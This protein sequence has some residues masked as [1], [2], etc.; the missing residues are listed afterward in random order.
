MRGIVAQAIEKARQEKV[1]GAA[2]E[3]SVVLVSGDERFVE[4][5]AGRVGEL[6]EFLIL[7]QLELRA[8]P[9]TCATLT[10]VTA[11]KCARC[12]RH[13]ASVGMNEEHPELC[14]R[15]ADVVQTSSVPA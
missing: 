2:L 7:S 10:R 11:E 5:W 12:W 6:E 8:G 13:R 1:I 15:C 4:R 3:A 9:E 14:D